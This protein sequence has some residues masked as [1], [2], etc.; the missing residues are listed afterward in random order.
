M[1]KIMAK[2]CRLGLS[3]GRLNRYT[4]KIMFKNRYLRFRHDLGLQLLVFYLLFVGLVSLAA[5]RFQAAASERQAADLKAAD[6]A[7]ARAVAQETNTVMDSALQA[8]RQLATY[9]EV[10]AADSSAMEPLFRTLVSVRTDVNLVYRLDEQGIMLYHYP[11]DPESTVGDDFSF[12]DYFQQALATHHPIASKGRIS[13]TTGQP[14]ATAVMPLWSEDGHFLG[15]VATNIK[16]QSFSHALAAIVHDYPAE[17]QLQITIVDSAGQIIAH[18][19]PGRLLEN[20]NQTMPAVMERVLA[21][22]SGSLVVGSSQE[23]QLFTFVPIRSAGWGVVVSRPTAV[24]FASL[25]AFQR[26]GVVAITIFLVGGLLFWTILAR[27]VLRPLERLATFS[28]AIGEESAPAGQAKQITGLSWRPDQ[29]GHLTRSLQRMEASIRAR[30]TELSTLLQTSA[31]VVS[32]LDSQIVLDRIL[33]QV[34]RLLDIQMSAV[35]ALD[36]EK[37]MFRVYA[38]R[39][40]P[41]WY[42]EHALIDPDEPGSVTMRAIRSGQP[43]Q[44]SDTETNPSFTGHR[45]RARIAGYRSV[46]AVPLKA[47]YIPPAAL[48]VYQPEP[49]EFSQREINLLSSFANHAAMA[50]ENAALFAHSDMQLQEQT[51][52]LEALIQSMQDGLILEDLQ[53]KVLYANRR[54]KD[55]AGLTVELVPGDSVEAFMN[56]L[57]AQ[58]QDEAAARAAVT[59][60]LS[61]QSGQTVDFTLVTPERMRHLRLQLFH[62]TDSAGTRI[63]RGRILRDIT[64]R[65]EVERMKSSLI[66]TVSHELRTP[67]AAIKGYTTTLLADDVEWDAKSQREFLDIISLET[68]HLNELVSDLLDMSRIE[69]G[70]L[71]VSRAA[72]DLNELIQQA[73]LRAH[74]QPGERLRVELPP[75]LPPIYADA[76]RIEAVLR[77]LIENAAKYSA[78]ETP[79]W[80]RVANHHDGVV[81]RVEDEGPGIPAEHSEQIFESFYRV[82]SGL[83]RTTD[84]AGLGLA[85]SQGFVRAHGGDIWLEPRPVGTCVAFS[86][87]LAP[88]MTGGATDEFYENGRSGH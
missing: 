20:T 61:G 5:Y 4:G 86:L 56:D 82:E 81:V 74:V 46:L 50:I 11:T 44:V 83:T 13:P 73:A 30:L 33:E 37:G 3:G 19:D 52:R 78:H 45:G 71:T 27:L 21:G 75:A 63:G 9:P 25:H 70:N 15:V 6:L 24:A 87:P 23:E 88:V 39:G 32:T 41:A 8:V 80:V 17:E 43:I 14:V 49:H 51:R 67:L 34:E 59:A 62:V 58:A 35:F 48:L 36:E 77:N 84:G 85:I 72:C 28:Q 31:A 69:A 57:L 18:A 76:R 47:R 12:R 42:I 79:I 7:L 29:I 55:V 1:I 40:L 64:Q 38:G 68:D 22:D 66:A 53:G 16:L 65:Y 60:T 54:M 2:L 10:I 26:G